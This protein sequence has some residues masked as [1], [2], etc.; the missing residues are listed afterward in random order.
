V[1]WLALHYQGSRKPS[2]S[3][4]L[5]ISI[6]LRYPEVSGLKLDPAEGKLKF[7]FLVKRIVNEEQETL[8]QHQL[9]STLNAYHHLRQIDSPQLNL[10]MVRWQGVTLVRLERDVATFTQEE[11]SLIVSLVN[12]NLPQGLVADHQEELPDEELLAQDDVINSLLSTIKPADLDKHLV[13]MR[14]AGKVMIFDS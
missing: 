10:R 13:A 11:L 1:L 4:Q 12:Q 8:F 14:T 7:S 2:D 9:N 3:A 5:L 6:L